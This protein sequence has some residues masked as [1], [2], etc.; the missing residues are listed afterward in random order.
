[1]FS[2]RNG[3]D[4]AKSSLRIAPKM[5]LMQQAFLLAKISP[6]LAEKSILACG[7]PSPKFHST[8]RSDLAF[9]FTIWTSLVGTYLK[10]RRQNVNVSGIRYKDLVSNP[11]ENLSEIFKICGLDASSDDVRDIVRK[12]LS[13]DSQENSP[14]R[15]CD[16]MRRVGDSDVTEQDLRAIKHVLDNSSNGIESYS[17]VLDGTIT[18]S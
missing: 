17:D 12:T 5:P 13:R 7:V 4:V 2:Y 15:R 9:F 1:M 6:N 11:Q 18:R 8:Q 10:F 16:V 14:L 3:L